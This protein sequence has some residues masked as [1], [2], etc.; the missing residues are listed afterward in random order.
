MALEPLLLEQVTRQYKENK[1][2]RQPSLIT[3]YAAHMG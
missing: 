1:E 2:I 3:K